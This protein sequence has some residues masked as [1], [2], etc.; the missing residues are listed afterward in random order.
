MRGRYS[1]LT[2]VLPT[3]NEAGN[4]GP[5]ITNLLRA[6][7]GVKIIIVDGGSEDGTREEVA[8]IERK[9][10][11][12]RLISRTP[13]QTQRGLTGSVVDGILASRTS[14]VVVMDADGQHPYKLVSKV[15]AGLSRVDLVICTRFQIRNWSAHRVIISALMTALGRFVLLI[16]GRP[17]PRDI[18]SGFFG[19]R[20]SLFMKVY[21]ANRKRFVMEG[22]KVL[23]DFLKSADP[24]ISISELPYSFSDRKNGA[25][26]A[27]IIHGIY[28][29]KS[30]FT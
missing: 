13:A 28:L 18:M 22:F 20:R 24:D 21:R 15:V 1:N 7:N 29:L 12:V 3:M 17:H 25:S 2:V 23:F 6:Y 4:V 16:L 8:L 14:L 26:N 19:I 27:K 10:P 11:A 9:V 30:F 5:L